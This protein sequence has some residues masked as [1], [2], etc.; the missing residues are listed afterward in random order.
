VVSRSA[1]PNLRRSLAE[2]NYETV[3][4]G[5]DTRRDDV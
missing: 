5:I 4:N 1:R 3:Y 2:R